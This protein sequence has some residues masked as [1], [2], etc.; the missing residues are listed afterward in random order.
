M[1]SVTSLCNKPKTLGEHAE[2]LLC[3]LHEEAD[4]DLDIS[5][6]L[7]RLKKLAAGALVD[8]YRL[9][10]KDDILPP[11]LTDMLHDLI[12]FG[13]QHDLS[14]PEAVEYAVAVLEGQA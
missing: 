9:G 2:F 7:L 13:I 14:T 11:P 5:E 8:V 10:Q 12:V 1:T 3:R 4:L 6:R